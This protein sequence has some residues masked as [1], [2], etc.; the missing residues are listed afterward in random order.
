MAGIYV[1]FPFCSSRCIYCDFYSGVRKD[2]PQYVS[3]LV[4]EIESNRL[5]I[6][7]N[8]IYFGGGTPSILPYG[9]LSRVVEALK[10]NF[11]LSR[12]KEFTIECNPDDITPEK[13]FLLHSLGADRAS[14]GVQ[15]FNDNHLK[16]MKRRHTAEGAKKAFMCLRDSGFNN[17]SL[18]LIFGFVGLS[19]REWDYSISEALS[20]HPEHI[21][22]YQMMGRYASINENECEEQYLHLQHRLADAGFEQYEISNYSLPG[23][24]SIHNQGYWDRTAYIGF[25]AAAHSFDGSLRRWWNVP[26]IDRY[27]AG[28][29]PSEEI[30]TEKEVEEEKIM[31]GLRTSKGIDI[32]IVEKKPAFNKLVEAGYIEKIDS[33]GRICKKK[34][35]VSDWIISQLFD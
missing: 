7:P 4:K 17:I 3:A 12:V 16:W 10:S 25:G 6:D 33:S 30:L 22:C 24:A 34:M 8:T 29:P 13:A 18:D 21:S 28:C 1:H 31:L 26:D 20:L 15:S 11:D 35:F 14:M 27:I 9:E 2:W 23:K 5:A 19:M 32:S